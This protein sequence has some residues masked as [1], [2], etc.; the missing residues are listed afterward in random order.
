MRGDMFLTP[1]HKKVSTRSCQLKPQKILLLWRTAL[2]VIIRLTWRI[3]DR[4][5]M[6][7]YEYIKAVY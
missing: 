2:K 1:G 5:K 6:T 7:K 3:K 4:L